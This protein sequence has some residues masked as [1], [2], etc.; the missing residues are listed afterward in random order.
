MLPYREYLGPQIAGVPRGVEQGPSLEELA[1]GGEVGEHEGLP[2]LDVLE[3]LVGDGDFRQRVPLIGDHPDVRGP[4]EPQ[5]LL[6]GHGVPEMDLLAQAE[7]RRKATQDLHVLSSAIAHDVQLDGFGGRHRRR[8]ADEDSQ[9]PFRVD[10]AHVDEAQP[11]VG[12]LH[13]DPRA[14]DRL[15]GRVHHDIQLVRRAAPC[16]QDGPGA[17][18]DGKDPV[19]HRHARRLQESDEGRQ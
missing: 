6:L 9:V 13:D 3:D 5:H 14:V 11:L 8:R 19:G 12:L 16:D 2:R 7:V 17:V 4:Q 18:V 1:Q 15:V 10:A